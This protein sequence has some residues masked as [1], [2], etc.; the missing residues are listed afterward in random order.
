LIEHRLYGIS[1]VDP[2]M[3]AVTIAVLVVVACV[4]CWVPA[5]RAATLDPMTALRAE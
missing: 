2:T 4:A 5:R 3:F 1:P